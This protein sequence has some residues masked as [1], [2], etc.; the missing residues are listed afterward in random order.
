MLDDPYIRYAERTGYAPW[1]NRPQPRCPVCGAEC[2]TIYKNDS[3]DIVGCDE[4]LTGYDA[5]DEEACYGRDN[6]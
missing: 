2:E 4:C 1:R 3:L 6:D 5:I